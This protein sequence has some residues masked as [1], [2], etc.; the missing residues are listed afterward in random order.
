MI[1]ANRVQ[2]LAL[3]VFLAL[4]GQTSDVF[5]QTISAPTSGANFTRTASITVTGLT[6]QASSSYAVY[7][8]HVSG[9]TETTMNT[10]GGISL[11]DKTFSC[12]IPAPI[13]GWTP[14]PAKVRLYCTDENGNP[15]DDVVSINIVL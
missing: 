14:G 11:S 15:G 10:G 4:L 6:G 8:N 5:G 7:I 12:T 13:G 9:G 2:I 3:V 1:D